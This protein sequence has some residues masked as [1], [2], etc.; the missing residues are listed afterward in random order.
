MVPCD[1]LRQWLLETDVYPTFIVGFYDKVGRECFT[2]RCWE[3]RGWAC[4]EPFGPSEKCQ[5][6]FHFAVKVDNCAAYQREGLLKEHERELFPE[7][8]A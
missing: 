6:W 8:C 5:K 1:G 4:D 3:W 2:E 7:P